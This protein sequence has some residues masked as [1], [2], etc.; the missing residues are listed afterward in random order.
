[1][2]LSVKNITLILFISVLF[3]LAVQVANATE[4]YNDFEAPVVK[5][6]VDAATP[7]LTPTGTYGMV[8]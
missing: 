5:G 8:Y 7:F 4:F 3:L 6:V 2:S 1:M